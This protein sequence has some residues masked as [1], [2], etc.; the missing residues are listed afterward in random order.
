M[1]TVKKG[2]ALLISLVMV[3]S[4]T[5]CGSLSAA[6][7]IRKTMS[8]ESCHADFKA[9]VGLHLG[10]M[11][12]S[13]ADLNITLDGSG[14]LT[15]EPLRGAGD[16]RMEMID[17]TVDGRYYFVQEGDTLYLYSSPDG[18]DWSVS[19]VDLQGGS[20]GSGFSFSRESLAAIA[21]ITKLFEETGTET[22]NG[23]EATVY[24]GT[25][26]GEDLQALT[27]EQGGDSTLPGGIDLSALGDIP[28]TV[29]VDRD[30]N[31]VARV[32][33]DLSALSESLV[34]L[35]LKLGAQASAESGE[36]GDAEALLDLMNALDI[37]FDRFLITVELS[38]YDEVG[39]ITIPDEV[40]SSAKAA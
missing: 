8:A 27:Q 3:L 6:K 36:A 22:I 34:P 4:L 16:F 32:T 2:L 1:K 7:T 20:G 40:I 23:S 14:D 24:S 19:T 39:E 18:E 15:G 29:A 5:A 9:E 28:V 17:E 37:R 30:T 12:E 31:R 13:I 25:I 33:L 35:V 21:A 26:R 10:M 11:E 38:D